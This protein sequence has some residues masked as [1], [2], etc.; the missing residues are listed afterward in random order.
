M[1]ARTWYPAHSPALD[2]VDNVYVRPAEMVAMME[3]RIIS[4]AKRPKV[5]IK[6]PERIV[7]KAARRLAHKSRKLLEGCPSKIA[8]TFSYNQRK[9]SDTALLRRG[10]KHCLKINRQ[11]IEQDKEA[12]AETT[13]VS[14][15]NTKV[16][17]IRDL[18]ETV[19]ASHPSNSLL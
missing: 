2:V 16:Y 19:S 4:G 7:K 1:P 13:N 6:I 12:A 3:P 14:C 11:V 10:S 5:E 8:L 9:I 18:Q 17:C 15:K